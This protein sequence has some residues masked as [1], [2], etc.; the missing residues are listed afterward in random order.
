MDT[1]PT[2]KKLKAELRLPDDRESIRRET[3]EV[4]QEI[5]TMLRK[6]QGLNSDIMLHTGVRGVNND[7]NNH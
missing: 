3:R 5:D 6:I 7:C 2:S 1:M 4:Y